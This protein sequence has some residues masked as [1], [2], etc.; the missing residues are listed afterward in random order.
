MQRPEGGDSVAC[1]GA[2]RAQR[3]GSLVLERTVAGVSSEEQPGAGTESSWA[4]LG[5]RI[6]S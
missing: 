1:L 2:E 3:R 5:T 6:L 4:W